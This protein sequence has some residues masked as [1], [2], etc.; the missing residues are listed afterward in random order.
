MN[1]KT[2]L[3]IAIFALAVFFRLQ[4]VNWD[5]NAH[6]HPDERFLT[7]VGN[8]MKLPDSFGAYLDPKTSSFNPTNIGYP[9]FVYGTFPIVIN[10]L[11]SLIANT[12]NYEAFVLQGRVLAA[13][14]D[15]MILIFL[16][17]SVKLL[18]K[19]AMLEKCVKYWAIFL[20][21]I[22]V[23]PI[24]L[25][26]FFAADSFLNMFMFGSFYFALQYDSRGHLWDVIGS[27]LFLGLAVASKMNGIFILPL[28]C[29]FFTKKI[30]FEKRDIKS[31]MLLGLLF[32]LVGYTVLRLS[33]PY[34]FQTGNVFDF[35]FNSEFVNNIKSL[36]S[37][38][39]P[40]IWYPPAVQW[41]NTKPFAF[42]LI[43]LALFGLGIPYFF[44]LIW[45]IKKSWGNR[46]LRVIIIWVL[47]IFI[48]QSTQFVKVLRYFIY[49]YPFYALFA[50]IG[51]RSIVDYALRIKWYFIKR[52][53]R[54]A[55]VNILVAVALLIWP[56]LFSSIYFVPHTRIQAS[57]WI[58]NELPSGST[59]L[60]EYWDDALP[61][62]TVSQ[63]GKQFV[64]DSLKVFDPES[65]EK[66]SAVN[67]QLKS[68]DY[69]ILSSNRGWGSIPTV[70]EKY[71]ET[72]KFYE[73]LFNK[74]TSYRLI[75]T[76]TPQYYPY[77][78]MSLLSKNLLSDW[79]DE[80]F[81]VYDHP[82][83]FIYKNTDK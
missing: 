26:H 46:Y 17:K 54:R 51:I 82:T 53:H 41:I 78:S 22:A 80:S 60:S 34:Y 52:N 16:F 25:S 1:K 39:N 65:S 10:K 69:Y 45:G 27:A 20:Y 14:A 2:V 73:K 8:A 57:T 6:L 36:K 81:T 18:E 30:L 5:S 79:F 11:I 56:L 23:L 21:S 38:E 9:F 77:T 75:K 40:N 37:F 83:V 70:P 31:F 63:N 12:D 62:Y 47:G 68:A 24:Q 7:M 64:G 32:S 15:M 58:Y 29:Y 50:A 55:I 48:Y 44:T 19:K 76:F 33:A 59:I 66:W 35:S 4:N 72:K 67:A 28:L 71:P 13:F 61:V 43:N 42:S 49:L 3:L 74:Q